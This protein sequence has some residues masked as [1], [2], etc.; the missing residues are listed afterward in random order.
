MKDVAFKVRYQYAPLK[1]TFN[2]ENENVT[3]SFCE[4]MIAA[5][6]IYRKEDIDMMSQKAVNKGWGLNGDDTY[7][8]SF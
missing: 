1:E 7:D 3:R 5:K 2:D 8:I 6:K 4:K